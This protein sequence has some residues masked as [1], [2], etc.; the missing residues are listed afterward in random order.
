MHRVH[1][2]RTGGPDGLHHLVFELAERRAHARPLSVRLHMLHVVTVNGVTCQESVQPTRDVASVGVYTDCRSRVDLL[3]QGSPFLARL[4]LR[5][6]RRPLLDA[7]NPTWEGPVPDT[8]VTLDRTASIGN[9]NAGAIKFDNA[10]GGKRVQFL[11][12]RWD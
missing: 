4:R 6:A 5:P 12:V 8:T 9:A 10:G 3:L 1:G 2:A 7:S 11:S